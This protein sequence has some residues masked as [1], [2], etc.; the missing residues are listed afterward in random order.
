MNHRCNKGQTP[1][2]IAAQEARIDCLK[3]L[4]S[5][6]ANVNARNDRNRTPIQVLVQQGPDSEQ[7]RQVLIKMGGAD[8]NHK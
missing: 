7:C 5:N 1:L 6:N 3:L 8:M 2:H 4:L